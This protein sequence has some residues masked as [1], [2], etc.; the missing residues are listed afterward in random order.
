MIFE[1]ICKT[2]V[3]IS[4]CQEMLLSDEEEYTS[5]FAKGKQTGITSFSDFSKAQRYNLETLA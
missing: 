5:E 4:L 3:N 2:G 1:F